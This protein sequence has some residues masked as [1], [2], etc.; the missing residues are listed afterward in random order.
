MWNLEQFRKDLEFVVN[1]DS[2]SFDRDGVAEVGKFFEEKC[3]A[4]GLITKVNDETQ[5]LEARTHED[6]PIDILMLGHMDTVFPKGTV[7]ERPYREEGNMAYGQHG[8]RSRCC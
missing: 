3:K 7:A 4:M 8:L 1:I 6:G 2:G 5:T